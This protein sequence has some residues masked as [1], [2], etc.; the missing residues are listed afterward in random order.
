[1]TSISTDDTWFYV[2]RLITRGKLIKLGQN[3]LKSNNV[4][5]L[6]FDQ[7]GILVNKKIVTKDDMQNVKYDPSTTNNTVEEKSFINSFLGSI[8]QK[9]YGKRKF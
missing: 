2:E 3:V 4:L 5:K 6:E 7:Y 9:M 8:K 1:M